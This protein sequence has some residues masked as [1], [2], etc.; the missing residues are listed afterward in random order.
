MDIPDGNPPTELTAFNAYCRQ[1]AEALA[2]LEK[3]DCS[4]S[5]NEYREQLEE[6]EGSA[7]LCSNETREAYLVNG[8]CAVRAVE[9]PDAEQCKSKSM[10]YF[11]NEDIEQY[12]RGYNEQFKCMFELMKTSCNEDFARVYIK[13]VHKKNARTAS[14]INCTID[15]SYLE[16]EA[17]NGMNGFSKMSSMSSS[18]TTWVM[19]IVLLL[20]LQSRH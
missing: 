19:L 6:L 12:C 15:T 13:F 16:K 7:Y 14:T 11:R 18:V 17:D 1:A 20:H 2:C 5:D 9:S 10:K 3:L 8:T 4:D